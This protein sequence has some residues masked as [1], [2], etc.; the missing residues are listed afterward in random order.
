MLDI[1]FKKKISEDQIA[2]QFVDNMLALVDSTFSDVVD[3]IC[4]DPH[5]ES[6]PV[7]NK[8]HFDSFLLIVLAANLK[9]ITK[10]FN[11]KRD[12][13]L[14]TK[15]YN[16]LSVELGVDS[17]DLQ[18]AIADYQS[19]FSRL[20]HPSK[21]TLY[22]MSRTFFEKY[23]LNEF[24]QAYFKKMKSPNPI[25]LKRLDEIMSNYIWNWEA[26]EKDYKIVT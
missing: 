16:K 21:N 25:I 11:D 18:K 2:T 23:G 22:A 1:L 26:Y 4:L 9:F 24:Q 13:R 15:I 3:L 10:T 7:I 5:F 12:L 8:D 6:E 14:I 19:L 17:K 20:N